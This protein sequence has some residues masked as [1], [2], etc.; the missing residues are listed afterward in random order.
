MNEQT[1]TAAVQLDE[2]L[3]NEL[4]LI[5]RQR[6]DRSGWIAQPRNVALN[7]VVTLRSL[8]LIETLTPFANPGAGPRSNGPSTLIKVTPEGLRALASAPGVAA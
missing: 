3:L 5:A 6:P 2:G 4:R 1:T 8:G 7:T